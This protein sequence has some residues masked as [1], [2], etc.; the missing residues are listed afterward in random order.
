MK[1]TPSRLVPHHG[2]VVLAAMLLLPGRL[3][4][5]N[6]NQI[7]SVSPASA[8]Q[9]TNGLL[10]TFTLSS[11]P[12]PPPT[13]VAI[14][15]VSIGSVTG[16]ASPHTNQ[17]IIC[18][19]F[20]L[21]GNVATGAQNILITYGGGSVVSYKA[22]G[23]TITPAAG[24]GA[25]FTAS[26]TNGISP[27]TVN[28]SDASAGV[29]TNWFWDFG[30]G[31]TSSDTNPVHTYYATGNYTVSLTVWG[32]LGSNA[33]TRA[34]Y[35]EVSSPPTNGAY[36]VVDTGQ[37]NC[38]SDSAVIPPP[39]PGQPFYGQDGNIAGKQPAYRDQRRRHDFRF[40]HRFDVG[41]GA[42]LT[43]DVGGGGVQ[44][45]QLRGR[46]LHRLADADHQGALFAHEI[47][48]PKRRRFHQHDRLHSLHGHELFR[49]RL[50]AG[51]FDQHRLARD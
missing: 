35:V 46:R 15:G 7:S 30:D 31:R 2:G 27:L 21:P 12:P 4:A 36:A 37:T 32:P 50:R 45:D 38:Y 22:A 41:A 44:R 6:T 1:S 43:G 10:V 16:T 39:A 14:S 28:Y 42:R 20:N 3:A 25:N 47:H 29:V 23:F 17:Y 49:L 33:L 40:E 18:G 34:G 19:Q 5:T 51:H 11:A 24:I 13:S 9:G 26:P 8:Q 48:R